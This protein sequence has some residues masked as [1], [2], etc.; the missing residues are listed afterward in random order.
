MRDNPSVSSEAIESYINTLKPWEI[1]YRVEG[2]Y[3]ARAGDP[4]F[5]VKKLDDWNKAGLFSE[6]TKMSVGS[7]VCNSELGVF[8]GILVEAG[9]N[10]AAWRVW[11]KP[12]NGE[13]YVAICDSAEGNKESDFQNCD[14]YR[15]S[16]SGLITNDRPVQVAQLHIVEM[17]P[18]DF[19]EEVCCMATIYGECLLVYE[20][21]NTSGGT[22]RDRSRNYQNL[23]RRTNTR[24]EVE[25]E[26]EILGWFTDQYNKA[27][28][29][30]QLYAMMSEW[31]N[32]FCGFQSPDTY[33][34]MLSFQEKII[35]DPKTD[36]A[37]R[38]WGPAGKGL[39]DDTITTAYIMAYVVR[40]QKDF[41]TPAIISG[42]NVA[43]KERLS[44]LEEKANAMN[45]QKTALRKQPSLRELARHAR[46]NHNGR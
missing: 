44:P 32:D 39:H 24:I 3:S 43:A 25:A 36:L 14:I 20:V 23:Y 31:P 13:Y 33:R 37:K 30:E 22:I 19:I 1:A 29:L 45:R 12:V 21:N 4:Y 46:N 28:G 26:S 27:A 10:D 15:C 9:G 6:G 17:K 18:G 7:R 5:N 11:E 38:V 41:L 35:R 2:K 16:N 40:F 8:G 34:E 42:E